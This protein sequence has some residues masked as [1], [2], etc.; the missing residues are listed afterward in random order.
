MRYAVKSDRGLVREINEDSFNVIAG[1]PG[2]P[3]AFIIADGMG[4]HN[5]GEV[6]S[7][8]AV[9]FVTNYFLQHPE[10]LS[11]A[12]RIPAALGTAIEKA[13]SVLFDQSNEAGSNHGM[14]TT[15]IAAVAFD[16]MFYIGHV[17]DSRVYSIKDGVIERI[18]TDHSYIEELIRQGSLSREEAENHPGRN[19]IT[20]ALGSSSDIQVDIYSCPYKN[21]D[22]FL[23]CT[24]GLTNMV[25]ENNIKDIILACDDPEA[26]CDE[27]IR[28]ANAEGGDDNTTV[29]VILC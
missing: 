28:L 11:S 3:A 12:E 27:L 16:N 23:L 7:R 25:C 10:E 2:V 1:Y 17:G 5:S 8:M 21:G 19:L 22:A 18:T 9:D 20:R 29:V 6:A 15:F 24:D 14:G 13:N 26:T 4:G